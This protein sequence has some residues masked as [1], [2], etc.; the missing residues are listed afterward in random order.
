MKIY[1]LAIGTRMPDWVQT[2]YA[3]Y[4]MRLPPECGLH[5]V[6]V[7]ASKRGPKADIQRVVREE[8]ERL[9]AAIPGSSRTIAL[10]ERGQAWSTMELAEQLAGWLQDGRDVSLLVGGPDGLDA[11]CRARAERLWSLS[12]LTLPHAL[13]R[14]L[15]AEQLYR[16][17]SVLQRHP[18]HRA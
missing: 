18:Y 8:G 5:L 10:E 4:A 12:R 1:L 9:T 13:V 14:V 16:A 3:D 11:L 6:E 7:P 17:W 15:V 2:G